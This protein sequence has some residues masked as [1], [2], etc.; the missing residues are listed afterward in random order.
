MGQIYTGEIIKHSD[1]S[2][3]QAVNKMGEHFAKLISEVKVTGGDE[4]KELSQEEYKLSTF[5][6]MNFEPQLAQNIKD[7]GYKYPTPVQQRWVYQLRALWLFFASFLAN[8]FL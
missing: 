3:E 6:E 8:I 7:I 1:E 4:H 5:E 2:A